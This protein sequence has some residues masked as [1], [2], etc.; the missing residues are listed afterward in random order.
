MNQT[1]DEFLNENFTN[2]DIYCYHSKSFI[3]H[4]KKDNFNFKWEWIENNKKI[5]ENI[6]LFKLNSFDLHYGYHMDYIKNIY[7]KYKN[8]IN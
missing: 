1:F 6:S 8:K 5:M 3:Y 7:G 2:T 4:L